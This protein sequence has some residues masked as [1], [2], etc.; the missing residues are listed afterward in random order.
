VCAPGRRSPRVR[1]VCGRLRNARRDARWRDA[2][3]PGSWGRPFPGA[4]PGR[5]HATRRRGRAGFLSLCLLVAFAAPACG[6]QGDDAASTAAAPATTAAGTAVPVVVDTDL[7]SEDLIALAFLLSSRDADVLAVTVCLGGHSTG[8]RFVTDCSP[9]R[10]P[11]PAARGLPCGCEHSTHDPCQRRP[12]GACSN[13]GFHR[14]RL[15]RVLLRRRGRSSPAGL[16]DV[17]RP[18]VGDAAPPAFPRRVSGPGAP[19]SI[20]SPR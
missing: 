3:Q 9:R 13:R 16:P 20:R 6:G 14:S 15:R 19:R 17:R 18:A 11:R 12:R 2:R 7:G 8:G 4:T 10:G 5:R 1:L